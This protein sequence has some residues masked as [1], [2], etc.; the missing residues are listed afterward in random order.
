MLKNY[1]I[2][3][4]LGGLLLFIIIMIPNF[5]WFAMP[6]PNDILRN[7]SITNTIDVIASVCQVLMIIAICI[8][9]NKKSTKRKIKKP[10][11]LASLICCVIYFAAWIMYYCEIT[12][13][14]IILSLCF[15]PCMSFL[16]Y[17]IDR[18]NYIAMVPTLAFTICHLIF[19]VVN[20]VI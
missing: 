18:K 1:K 4:D 16:L 6:A 13:D 10:L 14:F 19:G 2:S 20:F 12:N 5:I 8:L 15:F 9:V 11:I 7:N 3:F 17:E